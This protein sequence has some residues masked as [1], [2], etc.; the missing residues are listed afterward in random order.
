MCIRDR[1]YGI[2]MIAGPFAPIVLGL[3]MLKNPQRRA[4]HDLLA[5]TVVCMQGEQTLL[6]DHHPTDDGN[7]RGF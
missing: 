1:L 3:V 2:G 6:N 4:L 5:G 7:T